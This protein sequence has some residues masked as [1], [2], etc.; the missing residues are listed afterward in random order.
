MDERPPEPGD[1]TEDEPQ[2]REPDEGV[3]GEIEP[4]QPEDDGQVAE[5]QP[6]ARRRSRSRLIGCLLAL[7]G[8]LAGA[9][10][11]LWIA[12]DRPADRPEPPENEVL[13]PAEAPD[14]LPENRIVF[15]P[16]PER[17][18]ATPDIISAE[19]QVIYVFYELGR[20]PEDA[21]LTGTWSHEGD[22][23]GELELTGLR[24][25]EGVDHARGRFELHPP[26]TEAD[27]ES[28]EG[29][30]AGFPPGIYEVEL[31][32][33]D[34]PDVTATGSFVALPRAAQVLAGGG[35]PEG[36]PAIRSLATATGV[37]E[38]GEP[39]GAAS[40]FP[41]DVGR[42]TTVFTYAGIAPGSV[43]TVR[44]FAGDDEIE[45]AR[46]E[47]PINAAEGWA[48]SWLETAE[49]ETLPA[50]NYRV[51]VH[52][53]DDEKPLASTGFSVEGATGAADQPVPAGQRS[54]TP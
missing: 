31:T 50:G 52:L 37:N 33:P 21:P 48:E 17:P 51:T 32:S 7:L 25:D 36:P 34:Y 35:E 18:E 43:L 40:T 39:V 19:T 29:G 3:L 9:G 11:G 49:G 10:V 4:E 12:S 46:T 23:L 45:A 1:A 42:I 26:A 20:V 44:W 41:S 16:T 30:A 53:G 14:A 28:A 27:G 5:P 22:A 2:D 6:R 13:A 54:P 47:I 24:R 8:A 15:S 38:E